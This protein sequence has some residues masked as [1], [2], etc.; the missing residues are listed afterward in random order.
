LAEKWGKI[1]A[2]RSVVNAAL[3]V[4]RM[5]GVISQPLS[6][7]V[8][9]YSAGETEQLLE[10]LD[11]LSKIM[12]VSAAEVRPWEQRPQ[13]A[14]VGAIPEVAVAVTPASGKQCPRCRIWRTTI[15]QN[16]AYKTI[17]AE[18]AATVGTLLSHG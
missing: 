13:D 9:I 15:G 8:I 12:I 6:A 17:C 14:F 11:T 10:S 2:V 7:K 5:N 3:D 1:L 16:G 4:A 18:C